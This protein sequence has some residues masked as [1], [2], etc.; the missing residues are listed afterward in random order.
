MKNKLYSALSVFFL[1]LAFI[2]IAFAEDF[3]H[4]HL[5]E[6]AKARLGKGW[7]G[8]VI[9]ILIDRL[10]LAKNAFVVAQ[11][12]APLTFFTRKS[13]CQ[14]QNEILSF[15]NGIKSNLDVLKFVVH[16]FYTLADYNL[17]V[18]RTQQYTIGEI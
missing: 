1:I 18:N 12:I 17:K 10:T 15:R 2:P 9:S 4:W 3:T 14:S 8:Q 5:P 7:A 13:N 16:K 11:F 6:G